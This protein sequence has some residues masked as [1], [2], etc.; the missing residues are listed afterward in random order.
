MAANP[1]EYMLLFRG[2]DWN[3][4][5]SAREM[6]D[7]IDRFTSWLDE[8]GKSGKLKIGQPLADTGKVVS[9]R[10]VRTVAD[11]PFA[12]SKE[13]VGGYWLLQIDS[14]EEAVQFAEACPLLDFGAAIEVRPI[15][16]QCLA[17]KLV[18]EFREQ[19]ANDEYEH[20]NA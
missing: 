8:L 5:L 13:A 18:D 16:E 9:G 7:A 15:L 10:K 20:A 17:M 4:D 19:A 14:M 12:E 1:T 6:Q 3:K 11:G 2:T